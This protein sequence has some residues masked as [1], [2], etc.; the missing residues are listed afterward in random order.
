MTYGIVRSRRRTV[1][2]EV[3]RE[4]R[5]LVRAPLRMPQG[6]IERFVASHAAWLEKAQAK[7]AARQAAHP[8]LSE[9]KTAA[10]R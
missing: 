10:L 1:A 8:P 5:V 7:V 3:T 6:E 2:L 9:Q 4:G